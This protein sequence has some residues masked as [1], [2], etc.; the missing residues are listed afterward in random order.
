MIIE[1]LHAK[2][3]VHR[4]IKLENLLLDMDGYIK[5][6]DFRCARH[7]SAVRGRTWT[8]CGTP[9]YISP[10]VFLCTGNSCPVGCTYYLLLTTYYLP[11][12]TDY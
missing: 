5:L 8:L 12:T 1:Y 6:G 3:I 4:D 9:E 7:I 2:R 11:L 10:E